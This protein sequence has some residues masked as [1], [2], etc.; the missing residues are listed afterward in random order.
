MRQLLSYF[1]RVREP[2]P[3][4]QNLRNQLEIWYHHLYWSE[5]GLKGHGQIHTTCIPRIHSDE[6]SGLKVNRDLLLVNE[7]QLDLSSDC[8]LHLRHDRSD[9]L[10]H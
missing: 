4:E 9:V 8:I 5:E 7:N 10:K 6:N 1:E 3:R 2:S